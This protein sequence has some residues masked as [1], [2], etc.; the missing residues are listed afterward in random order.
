MFT[1]S[2]NEEDRL[3]QHCVSSQH[4]IDT[5]IMLAFLV[6]WMLL[7]YNFS[8]SVSGPLLKGHGFVFHIVR[9][10]VI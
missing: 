3:S 9:F 2:L 7:K 1:N 10:D 5:L 4:S 6:C 8:G